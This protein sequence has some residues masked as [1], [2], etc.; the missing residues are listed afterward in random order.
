MSK[1]NQHAV[2]AQ[3]GACNPIPL[4][5]ALQQGLEELR[6]DN[7]THDTDAILTDPALRLIAHQLS[8]LFNVGENSDFSL[9]EYRR[10]CREVGMPE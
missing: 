4:I 7:P 9:D 2:I 6:G 5:R 10:L 1:R 3:Q 8:H